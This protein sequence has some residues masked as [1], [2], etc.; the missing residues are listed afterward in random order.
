MEIPKNQYTK[1]FDYDK[2]KDTLCVRTRENGDYIMIGDGK[3]KLLKRFF[4]DEKIPKERRD[5]ILLLTE[6]DHILWIIGH[7]ISESYKLSE[8]TRTVLEV[9]VCKGEKNG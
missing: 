6:G 7:R 9:R 5:Q 8:K 4:I 3:R 1:W 2:I